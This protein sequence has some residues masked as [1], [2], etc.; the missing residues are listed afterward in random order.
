MPNGGIGVNL[1][2]V[3]SGYL[4][5]S[6]LL[7]ERTSTGRI[8]LG[9]FYARRAIRLMPA[10]LALVIAWSTYA[11]VIPGHRS[12]LRAVPSILLYIGN[13]QRAF[14]GPDAI[15]YYGHTW[16]LSIEE[17]FYILWP[18]VLLIAAAWRGPRA[19]WVVQLPD[20]SVR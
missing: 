8:R 18:L 11:L 14:H 13:W 1:F 6:I 12:T 16:S 7:A 20:R 10:L 19:V 5:T 3:L 17:Q 15:G 2:F 9:R 4:I